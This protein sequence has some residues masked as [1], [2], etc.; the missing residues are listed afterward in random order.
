LLPEGGTYLEVG[1]GDC[2]HA[3]WVAARAGKIYALDVSEEITAAV[4]QRAK[5]E[6]VITDG[7]SVPVPPGS[8]HVA[9][10]DQLLE[11]LH[12]DDASDQ[13]TNIYRSLAPGGVYLCVTPNRLSGPH[14][15]SRYF[16]PVATGLH[17]K[18]YTNQELAIQ[19]REAGFTRVCMFLTVRGRTVTAPVL[20]AVGLEASARATGALGRRLAR[21]LLGTRALGNRIAAFK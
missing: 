16:D 19:M 2:A 3:S 13:L 6:V 18:E 21:T 8:V 5:I 11:H 12:P 10:S 7:R 20:A 15:I 4:A 14:D 9:F 1:A 17:L